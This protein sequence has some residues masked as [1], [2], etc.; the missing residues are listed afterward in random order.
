MASGNAYWGLKFIR[1]HQSTFIDN[2]LWIDGGEVLP[3]RY[4]NF[5]NSTTEQLYGPNPY[6]FS[7][8]L[9]QA[10][11]AGGDGKNNNID[12]LYASGK[13]KVYQKPSSAG[14]SSGGALYNYLWADPRGGTSRFIEFGGRTS[15]QSDTDPL[16]T[17]DTSSG[18]FDVLPLTINNGAVLQGGV[19]NPHHGASAQSPD[20]VGYF[21]GGM[22]SN[23]RY[24]KQLVKLDLN[25]GELSVEDTGDLP[26]VVGSQMTWYPIGKKGILVS[27][28]GEI[29]D[30]SGR[31]RSM[32]METI[33][34]YDI[35]S[36]KWY[37]QIASPADSQQGVP[38]D[39]KFFCAVAP[40]ST[41]AQP[42][43]EFILHGGHRTISDDPFK[44]DDLWALTL[45]TFQWIQY[46]YGATGSTDADGGY[47]VSCAIPNDHYFM[48]VSTHGFG[49]QFASEPF[50]WYNLETLGW[51]DYDPTAIGYA[52]PQLVETT[53]GQRKAP[54]SW[55]NPDLANVFAQ[56]FTRGYEAPSSTGTSGATGS[57]T[58]TNGPTDSSAPSGGNNGGGSKT[59]TGAIA[60]GATVGGVALIAI[61]VLI[62]WFLRKRNKKNLPDVP[63]VPGRDDYPGAP[64]PI[65][66]LQSP[67]GP[68]SELRGHDSHPV[69][70][71]T[72]Y[73]PTKPDL[74]TRTQSSGDITQLAANPDEK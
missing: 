8:D 70:I 54:D 51:G 67:A 7:L 37:S 58:S 72:H 26:A 1:N 14:T 18:N 56:A 5:S 49:Q 60:A 38:I 16:Y 65:S 4:A 2:T 62:W 22:D 36:S 41:T 73:I 13:L 23:G 6:L 31:I 48:V 39:R 50:A 61:G 63:F 17:Y 43:Y 52:R 35:L 12:D 29:L 64:R 9:N 20:G 59:N 33:W 40:S 44:L 32:P 24:L 71:D 69:E 34:V 55:D 30:S 47:N 45:P 11:Y 46:Y 74:S 10:I 21:L 3:T 15:L 53:V 25:S 68:I 19:T 27:I 28:G 66:E 42:S 57:P